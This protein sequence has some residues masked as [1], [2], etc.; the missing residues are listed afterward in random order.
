MA[1]LAGEYRS[2]RRSV[3]AAIRR[4]LSS[5]SY[6]L[7]P[8]VEAFEH[9]F[10][11]YCGVQ[12]G[13]GVGSGT[14]ALHLTLLAAGIGPGDEVI[15][16]PNTDSPTAAVVRHVGATVV[17]A[18]VDPRTFNMD[19]A[20]AAAAITSRTR[21][22]LPVHL[23]G[24]PA[25]LRDLAQLANR[26]G[27]LLVEDAA[28]AVGAQHDGKPVGSL[29]DAACFSLAPGKVLGGY[30][31]A[32]IVVTNDRQMA[33][34]IRILRNYGHGLDVPPPRDDLYGPSNWTLSALG[35]N[36]RLDEVHAAV[37]RVKLESLEERIEGRRHIAAWYD[38]ALP[39][40]DVVK[41]L[42]SPGDRHVFMAYTILLSNREAARAALA[43]AG[44]ATRVYYT[45]PLHLQPVFGAPG[46]EPA[47]MPNA[48]RI[49]RS[50]L[51]LPVHPRMTLADC[52]MVTDAFTAWFA[53]DKSRS[54]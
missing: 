39:D 8:E 18:D 36:E 12:Y 3:E 31:D 54:A 4:V 32:G 41:P 13:I 7:G 50:M 33:D 40:V 47:P 43:A 44:I 48:E 11:D 42:V 6:V 2:N 28:L 14:A 15:T 20:A 10:A 30:G 19:P 1:D 24:N 35:F 29:G 17:F 16:V 25:N 53:R 22:I 21:M 49:D 45:P 46:R 9:A 34:H 23:F 37:L 51:S 27:L 38:G 26:H 5:G 52:R